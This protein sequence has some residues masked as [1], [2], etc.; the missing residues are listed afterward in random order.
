MTEGQN[1]FN[2]PV[3]NKLRTFDNIRNWLKRGLHNWLSIILKNITK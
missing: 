3:N 1:P 2:Q